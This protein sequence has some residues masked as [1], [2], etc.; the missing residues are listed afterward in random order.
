M[1]KKYLNDSKLADHIRLG[2]GIIIYYDYKLLLEHRFDCKKW[3]L[4]GGAVEI[5]ENTEDTAIRE[6]YEETGIILNKIN[7]ELVGLYSDVN[8]NRIIKYPDNC[9]HAIDIIYKYNLNEN[10]SLKKSVESIELTF[11]PFNRLPKDIVPPA[12]VPIKDF[13]KNFK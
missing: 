4:I 6:C 1:Y 8:E 7:L 10:Y 3:G 9:F 11:F 5:G 13:I 12:K 2:V